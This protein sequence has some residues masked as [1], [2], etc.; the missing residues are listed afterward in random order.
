MSGFE[1]LST[2]AK[3]GE[4]SHQA[5]RQ[6]RG[7]SRTDNAAAG[8][9]MI[10]RDVQNPCLASGRIG[11]VAGRRGRFRTSGASHKS[12][13]NRADTGW[14]GRYQLDEKALRD[15]GSADSRWLGGP[16]GTVCKT[17]FLRPHRALY[18]VNQFQ[19]CETDQSG[20]AT[21]QPR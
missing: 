14:T 16:S 2:Q 13:H 9:S 7:G 19:D 3:V 15:K 12:S 8:L 17:L 10:A 11:I 21:A 6:G 4:T 5:F 1:S 18:S 20:R